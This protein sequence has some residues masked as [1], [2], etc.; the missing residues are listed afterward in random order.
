LNRPA[1]LQIKYGAGVAILSSPHIEISSHQVR[2]L[3]LKLPKDSPSYVTLN[4]ILPQLDDSECIR[5][6]L[7]KELLQR[8]GLSFRK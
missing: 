6:K 8:L 7:F 4:S 5:S 3:L 1:I 2:D